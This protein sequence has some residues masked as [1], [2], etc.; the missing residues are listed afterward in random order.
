V[1]AQRR[2]NA[3]ALN[4]DR[5]GRA[6]WK[7]QQRRLMEQ[8]FC[9]PVL[10]KL[11]RRR[12]PTAEAVFARIKSHLGFRRFKVWGKVL[13]LANGCWCVWRIIAGCW[14]EQNLR[15]PGGPKNCSASTGAMSR[16][17]SY[18]EPAVL[19]LIF[20]RSLHRLVFPITASSNRC[21]KVRQSRTACHL[22]NRSGCP[23]IPCVV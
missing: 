12:Q 17:E 14:P 9:S 2:P 4:P 23:T 20:P 22:A 19:Q 6:Q 3:L 16:F 15:W 8:R 21:P 1:S 11:Y 5:R 13:P 18:A 10:R 7:W